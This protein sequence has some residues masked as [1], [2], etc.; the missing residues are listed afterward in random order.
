MSGARRVTGAG[1]YHW[2]GASS[3]VKIR[4]V[5]PDGTATAE[6]TIAVSSQ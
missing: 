5:S 2:P 4:V 6:Y 3:A 1:E